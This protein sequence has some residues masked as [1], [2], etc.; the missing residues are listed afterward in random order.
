[1]D[2]AFRFE[3]IDVKCGQLRLSNPE[4]ST[5]GQQYEA[6]D[7]LASLNAV[8]TEVLLLRLQNLSTEE[9]AERLKLSQDAVESHF[10]VILTKLGVETLIQALN[11]VDI[12]A[13]LPR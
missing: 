6:F 3:N 1:M 7:R 4:F 5:I 13:R 12:A 9:V 2:E 10:I 11:L 8:E